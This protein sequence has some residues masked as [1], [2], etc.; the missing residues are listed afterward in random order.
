M[1]R[2]ALLVALIALGVSGCAAGGA[3]L[4]LEAGRDPVYPAVAV[5]E[6]IEGFVELSLLESELFGHEEGA[7]TGASAA[8][9]GV[10]EQAAIQAVASWRYAPMIVDGRAVRVDGVSSRV[11]FR[12]GE[13]WSE[14]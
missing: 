2:A 10:F 5:R 1:T 7:F 12:F 4:R 9:R 11:E 13:A 14:L 6:R 8:R 3:G